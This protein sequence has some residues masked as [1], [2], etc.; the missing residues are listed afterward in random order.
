MKLGLVALA[1]IVLTGCPLDGL[2]L[3]QKDDK[4]NYVK[5]TSTVEKIGQFADPLGLPY[6][7]AA[8]GLLAT[9]YTAIRG[10]Q[11][12]AAQRTLA[13][14]TFRSLETFTR[15][16]EGAPVA[17]A[18]KSWLAHDHKAAGVADMAKAVCDGFGHAEA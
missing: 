12:E 11:K 3:R 16:P 7:G 18:L 8:A 9:I 17:D 13:E 1:L 6:V 14:S 4:G 2:F 10:K 5:G 15:A